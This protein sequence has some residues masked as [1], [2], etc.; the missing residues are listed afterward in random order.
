[1]VLCYHC[2]MQFGVGFVIQE[3]GLSPQSRKPQSRTAGGGKRCSEV[4]R[5]STPSAVGELINEE[6]ASSNSMPKKATKEFKKR[7][8]DDSPP[9][10]QTKYDG[11]VSCAKKPRTPKEDKNGL[12]MCWYVEDHLSLWYRT[13]ISVEP[14]ISDNQISILIHWNP[15]TSN[16]LECVF[17][18]PI[19]VQTDKDIEPLDFKLS[20]GHL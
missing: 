1:M 2:P 18:Q 13:V 20:D 17:N 6:D 14:Q 15:K 5:N 16:G 9:S 19:S 8:A 4:K 3:S 12:E 7:K 10:S 11:A